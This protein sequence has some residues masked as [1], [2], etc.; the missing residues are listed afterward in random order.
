MVVYFFQQFH[1][2]RSC[3]VS[4]SFSSSLHLIV[5]Y[6]WTDMCIAMAQCR[7]IGEKQGGREKANVYYFKSVVIVNDK[8]IKIIKKPWRAETA[9]C[10][11]IIH[12]YTICLIYIF[13]LLNSFKRNLHTKKKLFKKFSNEKKYFYKIQTLFD[14]K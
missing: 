6:A 1:L 11:E 13:L 2:L 10:T 5:R 3:N 4:F 12:T 14:A 8:S 9:F 7:H